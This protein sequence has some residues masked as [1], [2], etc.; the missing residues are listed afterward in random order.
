MVLGSEMKETYIAVGDQF[1]TIMKKKKTKVT[2][3]AVV[4]AITLRV[5]QKSPRPSIFL[6]H[7]EDNVLQML[8]P[9]DLCSNTAWQ[10]M[11]RIQQSEWKAKEIEWTAAV[12]KKEAIAYKLLH[13]AGN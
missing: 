7:V 2:V 10:A 4:S 13:R 9:G 5:G 12:R 1:E 8:N 11:G 6:Q 3:R